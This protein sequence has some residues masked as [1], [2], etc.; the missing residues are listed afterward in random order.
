MPP[1]KPPEFGPT[2][3]LQRAYE[4]GIRAITGRVLVAQRPEQSFTQWLTELAHR[5]NQPDIQQASELLARRMVFFT[6]KSNYRTW[7]EAAS[8]T[9]HSKQLHQLLEAEMRGATGA[10]VTQLVRENAKLISSLSL[11]AATTLTDE[12]LRAQQTG[13]RPKTVA[14]MAAKRFPE[15][16]RSRTNL[17]SRTETAKA[18][19]ALTQARC[20]RLS[21]EWY[22]WES[23]KDQRTR[24]SHKNMHGVI[25]PWS[26]APSP[27][28]LVSEKSQGAYQAGE[29]YNCRCLV[30]PILT[31]DDISFPARV[32]WQGGIKRMTKQDFKRVAVGLEER[33]A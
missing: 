33:T 24:E 4:Q 27:E 30:I 23:S 13:A 3:R 26:Q 12:I 2:Q 17:I 1:K 18:S 14:K 10:R 9:T 16:L 32:Y 25:V 22:Q 19:S 5:S 28:V 11:D 7:R 6:Q 31:L 29:I 15:L 8:R 21:I 20:E